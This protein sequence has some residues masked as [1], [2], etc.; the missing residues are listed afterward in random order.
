M[1]LVKYLDGVDYEMNLGQA[2]ECFGVRFE[3]LD[4][5]TLEVLRCSSVKGESTFPGEVEKNIARSL[6]VSD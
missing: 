4:E 5:P 3:C 2:Q 6:M 1:V